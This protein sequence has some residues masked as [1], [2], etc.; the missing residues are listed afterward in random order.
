MSIVMRSKE[1]QE[2]L[3]HFISGEQDDVET[4]MADKIKP[5]KRQMG[6]LSHLGPLPDVFFEPI[7]DEE[8]DSWGP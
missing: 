3:S 6:F 2:D 1:T 8:L 4:I 7:S 5:A